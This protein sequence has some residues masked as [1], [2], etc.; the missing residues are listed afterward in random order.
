MLIAAESSLVWTHA[1]LHVVLLRTHKCSATS[2]RHFLRS[3]A[4]MI[5]AHTNNLTRHFQPCR[6]DQMPGPEEGQPEDE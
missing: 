1:V 5:H 3:L 6:A 4:K 2:Y